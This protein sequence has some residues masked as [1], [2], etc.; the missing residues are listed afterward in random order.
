LKQ[1]ARQPERQFKNMAGTRRDIYVT[2]FY[3]DESD[4]P[5]VHD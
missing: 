4:V 1:D 5:C 2:L 3:T